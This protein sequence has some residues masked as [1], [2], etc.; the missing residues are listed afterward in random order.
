MEASLYEVYETTP[1][2]GLLQGFSPR[3]VFAR[4]VEAGWRA[5]VADQDTIFEA[6][7]EPDTR[8]LTNFAFKYDNDFWSCDELREHLED[9]IIIYKPKYGIS[10]ERIRVESTRGELIGYA[11]RLPRFGYLDP[12]GAIEANRTRAISRRA[13]TDAAKS[14]PDVDPV[15]DMIALAADELKVTPNE[16]SGEISVNNQRYSK[17]GAVVPID[18]PDKPARNRDAEEEARLDEKRREILRNAPKRRNI[19]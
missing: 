7:S 2:H 12:A 16:P 11:S 6:C 15:G 8:D 1:Q 4:H 18:R 17:S 3:Q 9:K 13:L 14:I 10:F 5:T 19:I